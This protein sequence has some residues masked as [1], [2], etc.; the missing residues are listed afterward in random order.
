MIK[1]YYE[2]VLASQN[3]TAKTNVVWVADITTLDLAEEKKMY[4]FL[5]IDIHTNFIV[6][7][8]IS[9]KIITTQ[10]ITRKL[11]KS[12]KKRFSVNPVKR[13]II[14]TDRGTQFSSQSYNTFTRKYEE[15]FIPSMAREN[16]PTDN[17]V[18]ERFMRTFKQHKI[19]NI[20]VEERLST[21]IAINSR[22]NSY[23]ACLN[24]YVKSLNN[25]PNKKSSFKGPEKHY[26][27]VLT[28]KEHKESRTALS[29]IEPAKKL[30]FDLL[31]ALYKH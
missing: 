27:D 3:I 6:S 11:E 26:K 19:Y 1:H 30:F 24:K 4:V 8:L 29:R 10:N 15:Y 5:C 31:T 25:K 16:T 22:F 20:T 23:R 14:H 28:A 18:A 13:L 9:K 17:A 2:N 21:E 12:I 7:A